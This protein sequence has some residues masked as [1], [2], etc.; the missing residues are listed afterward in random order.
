[1]E[2]TTAR[3]NEDGQAFHD[4]CYT[5]ILKKRSGKISRADIGPSLE[6]LR[7]LLMNVTNELECSNQD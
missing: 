7:Y 6:Y 5:S 2:L 4:D 3:T 1:M